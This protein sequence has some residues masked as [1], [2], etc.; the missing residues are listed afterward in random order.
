MLVKLIET[1]GGGKNMFLG[2]AAIL[3]ATFFLNVSWGASG[4]VIYLSEV[5]ELIL[6]M[7]SALFFVAG[8]LKREAAAKKTKD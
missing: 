5:S 4:G 3:F 2:I 7:V 1:M 8:I 6:L